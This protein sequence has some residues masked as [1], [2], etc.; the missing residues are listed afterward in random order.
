MR[1]IAL[2]PKLIDSDI[3]SSIFMEVSMSTVQTILSASRPANVADPKNAP[4][5]A[6]GLLLQEQAAE[7]L[8]LK[9]STLRKDRCTREIGVPFVKLGRLVR[10]RMSDLESFIAARIVL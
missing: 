6:S 10:Y 2:L 3:R 7:F 1:R 9:P 5:R 8:G 4:A